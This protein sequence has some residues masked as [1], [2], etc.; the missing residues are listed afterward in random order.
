MYPNVVKLREPAYS[1]TF[2]DNEIV[3]KYGLVGFQ[4]KIQGSMGH[5]VVGVWIIA[6]V[7]TNRK[8][9]KR[10]RICWRGIFSSLNEKPVKAG[11]ASC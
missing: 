7:E 1:Q 11:P 4:D 6:H 3:G 8:K 5:M 2:G 10:D 9:R